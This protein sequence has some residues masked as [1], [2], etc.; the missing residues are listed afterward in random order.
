MAE[1]KVLLATFSFR[2]SERTGRVYCYGWLGRSK[3]I[4]FPGEV[5]RHGNKT[6]NLYLQENRSGAG[7]ARAGRGRR[8]SPERDADLRSAFVELQRILPVLDRL[9]A[10]RDNSRVA[11]EAFEAHVRSVTPFEK[12][13]GRCRPWSR[14]RRRCE[15]S[16]AP[17]GLWWAVG[18]TRYLA[19]WRVQQIEQPA[20]RFGQRRRPGLAA[21]EPAIAAAVRVHAGRQ[22]DNP[23]TPRVSK[24]G[25]SRRTLL[26]TLAL[27]AKNR[28]WPPEPVTLAGPAGNQRCRSSRSAR[29]SSPC[30]PSTS[31]AQAVTPHSSPRFASGWR[32]HIS[33]MVAGSA[34]ASA[35]Q[36][37]WAGV[38]PVAGMGIPGRG[39]WRWR[40]LRLVS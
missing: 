5:D 31:S 19:P 17:D 37:W 26:R 15:S 9:A 7:T 33:A 39:T 40:Q 23:P 28:C 35:C 34:V 16:N 13:R 4:G 29:A 21:F 12:S 6:I 27:A 11:D 36:P 2:V 30:W 1:P 14:N 20:R 24:P 18:A 32:R 38:Y 25:P 22:H 8:V 10:D 3:L